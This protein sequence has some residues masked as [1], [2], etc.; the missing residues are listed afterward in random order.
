MASVG[1]GK[2]SISI[3][4]MPLMDVFSVLI[5]FLLMSYSSDPVNVDP[6]EGLELPTSFTTIALEETPTLAVTRDAIYVGDNASAVKVADIVGGD[7][8]EDQRSQGAIP[9]LYDELIKVKEIADS[10]Q[11]QRGA[12]PKLGELVMEMDKGHVFKLVKRVM[13]SAQQAEF[14]TFNLMVDRQGDI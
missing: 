1:G 6:R 12:K 4:I 7:I 3:N 8:P 14:V 5:T 13:L 11:E 10:I 9:K 2:E